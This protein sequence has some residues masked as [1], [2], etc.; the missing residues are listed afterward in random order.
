MSPAGLFAGEPATRCREKVKFTGRSLNQVFQAKP[1]IIYPMHVTIHVSATLRAYC[2]ES[3]SELIV[4]AETV[5]E[6]LQHL[7]SDYPAIHQSICDETGA[8]RRHIHLFVNDVLVQDRDGF[9]TVLEPGDIL[10][11]MPA[12]SGG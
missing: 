6:A 11:I 5:R 4:S 3:R 7:E 2:Q 12:V 10:S 1:P 8:T 9:D